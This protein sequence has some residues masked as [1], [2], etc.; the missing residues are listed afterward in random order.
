MSGWTEGVIDHGG[1]SIHYHRTGTADL[2]PLVLA[3]GFSDNGLCWNRLAQGLE[4]HFD[5]IMPDARN[6]GQSSRAPAGLEVMADDLLAVIDGLKLEQPVVLGH[7]MGASMAADLAARN[8]A[9]VA[10]LL[11]EDPPWTKHQGNDRE[12][13][14]EKRREG[15]RQYMSTLEAMSEEQVMAFGKQTN[16]TWHEADMAAWAASKKQVGAEAM[17][18]LSMGKW[19]DTV[20]NIRCPSLLLYADGERDAIVT[21]DIAQQI[22]GRNDCFKVQHIPAAGHNTRRENFEPYLAAVKSFLLD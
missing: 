21:H 11:L 3:H 10:K 4:A 20:D 1:V 7:S 12:G 16:P 9:T 19:A 13:D 15:F 14:L 2:P 8:P 5:I 18:G 17:E 22:A 6:H